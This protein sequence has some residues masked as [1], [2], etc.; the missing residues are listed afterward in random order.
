MKRTKEEIDALWAK[1]EEA[2]KNAPKMDEETA[3]RL[4]EKWNEDSK[5]WTPDMITPPNE[6]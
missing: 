3:A 1:A 5:S 6:K 2:H 4:R